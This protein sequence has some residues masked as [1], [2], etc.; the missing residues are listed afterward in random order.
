MKSIIHYRRHKRGAMLP[1]LAVVLVILFIAAALGVDIARMHLTRA[2]LRTATDAAARAAT[3]ALGR[4][5]NTA[6]ATDAAMA[7]AAANKVAGAPLTL[8]PANIEFGLAV[9]Q[10]DGTYSFL[11][12]ATFPVNSVRIVGDRTDSS[13]DGGVNMMFGP[14]LGV[15][16]FQPQMV[17]TASR[18]DRDIAMVLDISGSMAG[19]KFTGLTAAVNAFLD[20]LDAT[21]QQEE[22]ISL[23]VYSN[24]S[25]LL[26]PITSSTTT[27]RTAF[28]SQTPNGMTAI[29]EGLQTGMNSV[30]SDPAARPLAYKSILLMTDGNHNTGVDPLTI[31]A[32]CASQNVVVNT[33]TFGDDASQAEMLAC[34]EATGG[35][36]LHA[37]NTADLI[38]AFRTI[39]RQIPVL[40][41]E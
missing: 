11:E 39:A 35:I 3:E 17:A 23:T 26:E 38:D 1:F 34:A 2:E 31:S 16:T 40:L 22:R 32:I 15:T 19:D 37:V 12:T 28:A 21:P 8:D 25:S 4:L 10:T 18:Q 6:A 13:P 30:L 24:S 41:I 9:E 36:H 20:E 27:I 14:L 33:V 5:Q 29:G 7:T